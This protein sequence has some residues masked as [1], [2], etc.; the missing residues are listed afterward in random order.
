M[1]HVVA[2]FAVVGGYEAEDRACC[3][4]VLDFQV[5]VGKVL[6]CWRL[7]HTYAFLDK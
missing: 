6:L 5:M 4:W 1:I 7:G 3:G 2:E